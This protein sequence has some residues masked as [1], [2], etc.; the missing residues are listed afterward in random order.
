MNENREVVS[1]VFSMLMQEKEY[2]LEVYNALNGTDYD[3]PNE[4]RAVTLNHRSVSLT[5][6]NDAS[7]IVSTDLNVYEHQSTYNPNMPLRALLYLVDELKDFIKDYD[8]YGRRKIEIPTPKFAVF[9][10]GKET[11]PETEVLKLSD[12]FKNLKDEP[13]LELTCK[14][15]NINTGYN[16]DLKIEC[17]VL[18][19]YMTFVSKVREFDLKDKETSVSRAIDWCLENNVLAEFLE[20]R[21]DE[22][23]K[24]KTLD[25]T[26]ERREQLIRRDERA[27]GRAEGQAMGREKGLLQGRAENARAVYERCLARGM[28]EE[29][30]REISGIDITEITASVAL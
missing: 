15:Y 11:R 12:L 27:E 13:Q 1:D 20:R 8:I 9:Y 14:V 21:K 18:D 10:N 30:A 22:V 24:A 5:M 4:V 19:E 17:P 28:S 3:D 25:M 7:F 2:A 23:K 26:W 16:K 6:K 29:D